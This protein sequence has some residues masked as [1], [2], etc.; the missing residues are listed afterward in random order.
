MHGDK[1]LKNS[2]NLLACTAPSSTPHRE[3]Q[4]MES[5]KTCGEQL[6]WYATVLIVS[7]KEV[8]LTW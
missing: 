5:K 1:V 2:E 4:K 3:K 7:E 8:H 6:V